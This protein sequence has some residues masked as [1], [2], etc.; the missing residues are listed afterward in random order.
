MPFIW[1]ELLIALAK[2][3]TPMA[4]NMPDKGHPCLTPLLKLLKCL[5]AWPFFK[6]E[7]ITSLYKSEIHCL[8]CE[9]KLKVSKD[10]CK[11]FH[12]IVSRGGFRGGGGAEG[13]AAPSFSSSEIYFFVKIYNN[14]IIL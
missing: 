12:S 11:Y 6:T 4:N 5:V 9:P 3:S 10:F 14:F 2:I 7:F 1:S 8:N 13:A